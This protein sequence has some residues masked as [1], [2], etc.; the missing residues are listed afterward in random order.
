ME[1]KE[2]YV[3]EKVANWVQ[4]VEQL[5]KIAKEEPQLA[6]AG[7]NKALCMRW[8]FVQ[9]TISG[10]R[11]LFQPLEDVI[12]EKLIPAVVGR[13]VSDIEREILALPVRFGGIGLMNPV[14]TADLEFETSVRITNNL[15]NL[16]VNQE[17]S[18]ENL[19]EDR[20]RIL[21]QQNET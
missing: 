5:T 16:I 4:D 13:K 3:S 15:T 19:D 9:R 17:R 2:K 8:C 10:I 7:F 20:L 1:F 12:R 14:E 18:L 21:Y 6:L 11:D